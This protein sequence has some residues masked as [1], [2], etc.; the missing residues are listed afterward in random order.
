[1]SLDSTL[2]RICCSAVT[3]WIALA[4]VETSANE[5]LVRIS[6]EP[7]SIQL[8]ESARM[9]V[10][11]LVPTWQPEPPVYP[12]FEIPNAVT[13]LPPDS[14]NPTSQRIGGDSWSGIVRN[15]EVTP[16]IA[17]DFIL[18]GETIRIT[19]ADPG[20]SNRV[21]DVQVPTVRLTARVPEGAAGLDPYLAGSKFTIER[22]ISGDGNALGI[23]DAL[24]I[25]YRATLEGMP[26]LFIPPLTPEISSNLV[27]AYAEEPEIIHA[28]TAERIEKVTL[29][30][31]H[32]GRFELPGQTFSWWNTKTEQIEQASIAP[33]AFVIAGP[34]PA[35]SSPET[36]ESRGLNRRALLLA[37]FATFLCGIA[38][39][40]WLPRYLAARREKTT[41]YK[42]SE[43]YAFEALSNAAGPK[44]TYAAALTWL[45]R[46]DPN[47]ELNDFATRFG[48]SALCAEVDALSRVLFNDAGGTPDLN[49]FV[50]GLGRAR[51][52]YL[53]VNR[54]RSQFVLAPLNP[55]A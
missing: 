3:A 4:S 13:R 45:N 50:A 39:H 10:T 8:G 43:T 35:A 26:A 51:G 34:A 2:R 1:M 29:I 11:V 40:R 19:W 52:A 30:L 27:T 24:V 31:E 37:L 44:A 7:E 32:G 36:E 22:T 5:P 48:D 16:L 23:G 12:T 9:R 6:L 55:I 18:G 14:S 25:Q 17:A 49:L 15:Y 41:A 33:T 42:R 38:L 54:E 53:S 21:A 46:L 28:A 20:Q 47:L